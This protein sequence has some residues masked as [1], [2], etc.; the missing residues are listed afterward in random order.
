MSVLTLND[1]AEYVRSSKATKLMLAAL[2][3]VSRIFTFAEERSNRANRF[4][5]VVDAYKK[6]MPIL[7]IESK[8]GC[9]KRTI[10]DYVERAGVERRSFVPSEI[11]EAII[12]DYKNKVPVQT[13]ADLNNVSLRYVQKVAAEAGLSR[14]RRKVSE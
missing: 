13:I 8:F 4:V 11:K 14:K 7:E 9:S 12:R 5:A 2:R 6:G 1:A 10:Y 3:A